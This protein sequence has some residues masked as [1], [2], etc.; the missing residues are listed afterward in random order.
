MGK[1][2]ICFGS[3]PL[4]IVLAVWDSWSGL[5][6]DRA[7]SNSHIAIFYCFCGILYRSLLSGDNRQKMDSAHIY[8]VIMLWMYQPITCSALVTFHSLHCCSWVHV[9]IQ[10]LWHLQPTTL[11][12]Q[13]VLR[14]V[15]TTGIYGVEALASSRLW[16]PQHVARVAVLSAVQIDSIHQWYACL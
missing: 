10:L 1:I 12:S 9:G 8:T 16:C 14:P 4:G 7:M 5:Y 6:A 13:G 3:R 2:C 11:G 15:V